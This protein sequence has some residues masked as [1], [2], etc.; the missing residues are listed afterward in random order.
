MQCVPKQSL[1]TESGAA[2]HPA[3]ATSIIEVPT[4]LKFL[5]MVAMLVSLPSFEAQ[6]IVHNSGIVHT[7]D[8]DIGY[9]TF[10]VSGT[11]LPIILVNGGPGLSHG[12]MV[13]NDLWEQVARNRL[14]V[15]YDQRGTGASRRMNA[16]ASQSMDAQ[17]SDLEAV[18]NHLKL[19]KFALLGDSYGGLVAMAYAAAHPQYVAKLILS[20]S[21]GP[22]WKSI[23]HLLPET[24]PDVEEEDAAE[25]HKSGDNTDAAGPRQSAQSLSY[26][27]L[28]ATKAG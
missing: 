13:M 24:F 9:E 18:R 10:G 11:S 6:S 20:D 28:L 27:F 23:V 4:L 19:D 17:I 2:M 5:S 22:S 25:Q 12:Y 7:D 14:V 3:G 1:S 21:P 26:D 16:H 8:V 15:L